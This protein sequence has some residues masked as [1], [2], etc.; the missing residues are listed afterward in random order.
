MPKERR[1][2]KR[3]DPT[4]FALYDMLLDKVEPLSGVEQTFVN[5][6]KNYLTYYYQVGIYGSA[7]RQPG[8]RVFRVPIVKLQEPTHD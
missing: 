6:H 4:D 3:P 1:K 5:A 8:I 7:R 2:H